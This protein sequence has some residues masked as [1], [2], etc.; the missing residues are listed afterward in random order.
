MA[1]NLL[2]REALPYRQFNL[3]E[4]PTLAWRTGVIFCVFQASGGKLEASAE[5][6]SRTFPV[7]RDSRLPPL[8]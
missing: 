3:K 2:P 5:H 4:S 1:Y 8:A 7:T 6:E